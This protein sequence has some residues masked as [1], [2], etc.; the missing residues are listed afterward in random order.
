MP[1]NQLNVPLIHATITKKCWQVI[2]DRSEDMCFETQTPNVLEHDYV[3]KNRVISDLL[4]KLSEREKA[5]SVPLKI[6]FLSNFLPP[7]SLLKK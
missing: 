3:V 1:Q 7:P 5:K 6:N 4:K 2:H